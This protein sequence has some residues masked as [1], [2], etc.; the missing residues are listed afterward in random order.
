MR[1]RL[2]ADVKSWVFS[3]RCVECRL[4]IHLLHS[5][6]CWA[7]S[8]GYCKS[9]RGSMADL[10]PFEDDRFGLESHNGTAATE[11]GCSG[12]AQLGILA[13]PQVASWGA[14][15]LQPLSLA[16]QQSAVG[17]FS[18][19]RGR[20]SHSRQRHAL[21]Y[22]SLLVSRA[23]DNHLIRAWLLSLAFC[24]RWKKYAVLVLLLTCQH[25]AYTVRCRGNCGC[26]LGCV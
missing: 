15:R 20:V 26:G 17:V 7:E 21:K 14:S 9:Q 18:R 2:L 10:H 25:P 22:R 19:L 8:R 12:D 24:F 23:D 13:G 1:F 3:G 5:M 16:G 4:G 6:E 11:G